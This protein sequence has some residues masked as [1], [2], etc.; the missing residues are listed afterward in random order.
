MKTFILSFVL[1]FSSALV[2]GQDSEKVEVTI[3]DNKEMD[4]YAGGFAEKR[5]QGYAVSTLSST[6]INTAIFS[7]FT[8]ALVGKMAG[9]YVSPRSGL[10]GS[11]TV[12]RIRGI[13]TYNGSN[14][15]L[16]IVD[17]APYNTNL[18]LPGN[19]VLDNLGSNRS[20]DLDLNNIANVKILKGLAATNIYGSQGRN[21]VVLITTKTMELANR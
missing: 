11:A 16:F 12:F 1:V 15:P 7:D 18:N 21:G 17:G 8:T 5:K 20:F 14:Y 9:V 2:F 3:S 19:P 4:L 13:K 10:S 6:D